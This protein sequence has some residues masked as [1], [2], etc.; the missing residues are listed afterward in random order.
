MSRVPSL[1][2]P[3]NLNPARQLGA[4]NSMSNSVSSPAVQCPPQHPR[5]AP[6]WRRGMWQRQEPGHTCVIQR[7]TCAVE[8]LQHCRRLSAIAAQQGAC[9]QRHAA[10]WGGGGAPMKEGA[11]SP[12]FT[13]D[14]PM[15]A[16]RCLGGSRSLLQAAV[17][18]PTSRRASCSHRRA[19]Q[20]A[21]GSG[22]RFVCVLQLPASEPPMVPGPP[23]ANIAACSSGAAAATLPPSP[24]N[25]SSCDTEC[26]V[27]QEHLR[28]AV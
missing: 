22:M 14:R 15:D 28:S 12:Y 13:I 24:G 2:C 6:P 16:L 3:S 10:R 8:S 5:P 19:A 23:P 21:I 20:E 27:H 4:H 1:S 7:C 11:C 18:R 9:R 25:R 17:A 26:S